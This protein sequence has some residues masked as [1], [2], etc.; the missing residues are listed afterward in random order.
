LDWPRLLLDKYGSENGCFF[1]ARKRKVV[2]QLYIHSSFSLFFP[3][4]PVQTHTTFNLIIILTSFCLFSIEVSNLK[5]VPRDHF[6]ILTVFAFVLGYLV[7]NL[8][9]KTLK[10]VSEISFRSNNRKFEDIWSYR[11]N[12]TSKF[13]P[14]SEKERNLFAKL[15]SIQVGQFF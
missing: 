1:G 7:I 2:A 15:K 14:I 5:M 8:K 13:T 10:N 11:L 12:L 3:N 4:T 6:I 9:G